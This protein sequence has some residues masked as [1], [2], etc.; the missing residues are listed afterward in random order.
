MTTSTPTDGSRLHQLLSRVVAIERRE[1][2]AVLMSFATFFALLCGYYLIRP[3]R[4]EIGA[5]LPGGMRERLFTI[6]LVVMLVAVPL[7][8]WLVSRFPRERVLPAVYGFFIATLAI[9]WFLLIGGKQDVALATWRDLKGAPQVFT[10]A[11]AFFVWASVF[12][13][14]VI[15]LFWI[16]MSEIYS[17]EQAKRLYGFIAAGGTAGAFAGPLVAQTLAMLIR[18]TNLLA[19]AGVLLLAAML[20]AMALR[21]HHE[22]E[23]SEA[24]NHRPTVTLRDL[25]AGAEHVWRSPYLFRIALWVLV[26]NVIGTFFYLEQSDIIGRTMTNKAERVQFL[27]RLDLV[28]SVLT[29]LVQL[30][31]TGRF[32]ERLGVG[33]AAAALP[34]IG[35]LGLLALSVAPSLAIVAGVLVAE[36]TT[37]FALSSPAVKVMYT[38]VEPE[39]KY[40]AQNFIDTVVYRGGDAVSGWI[41]SALGRDGLGYGITTIALASLPAALGWLAL[42]LDLGRRQAAKAE[43]AAS[44]RAPH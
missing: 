15:S 9:F 13:L 5:S 29:I 30:A 6:V 33:P 1:I 42:S 41:M 20:L 3:V 17:S 24:A 16:L 37:A 19:I 12:N 36:R 25:V 38:V 43:P 21:R 35:I 4:D 40:K 10:V 31:G 44:R 8:G 32:M 28:V 14:F 39:E 27:A 2:A 26:A 11:A 23:G 18:P 22:G 7:F 34:C